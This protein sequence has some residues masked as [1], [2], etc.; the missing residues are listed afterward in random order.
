[1]TIEAEMSVVIASTSAG[2]GTVARETAP[3]QHTVARWPCHPKLESSPWSAHEPAVCIRPPQRLARL[4]SP[5]TPR[6][7]LNSQRHQVTVLLFDNHSEHNHGEPTGPLLSS[8]A[9]H[10]KKLKTHRS[11]AG[12]RLDPRQRGNVDAPSGETSHSVCVRL[13]DVKS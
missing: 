12:H 7:R 11:F 3:V 6:K 2:A 8:V 4:T 1:M 5:S 9:T 10:T 13:Q